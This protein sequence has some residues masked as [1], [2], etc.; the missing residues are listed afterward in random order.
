MIARIG[1]ALSSLLVILS[2]IGYVMA[3]ERALVA[4]MVAMCILSGLG[5]WSAAEFLA[6]IRRKR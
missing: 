1:L 4:G 6:A 3:A 5:G 2:M